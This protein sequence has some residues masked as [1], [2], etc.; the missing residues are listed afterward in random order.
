MDLNIA[1][2]DQRSPMHLAASNGHLAIVKYLFA[3]GVKDVNPL[4]R[5]NYTPLDDSIRE[6]H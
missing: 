3:H 1:D 5:F 4:D 2:Y 6:G